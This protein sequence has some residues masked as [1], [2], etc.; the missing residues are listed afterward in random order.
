VTARTARVVVRRAH[1]GD[2]D[3][4]AAM[5]AALI[6]ASR[7]NPAYRR[8]RR[9]YVQVARPLF[10]AQLADA[11]C[12]TLLATADAQPVGLLR[13]TLSPPNPLHEPARHAYVVSVYVVPEQR[14]RGV[15]RSLVR[16]AERWC[17]AHDIDEMRLHVG[18]EN[19]AGNAAW[20]ALGF[21]PAEVLRVRRI[22][23]RRQRPA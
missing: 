2:L 8:L 13:C 9:D 7:R 18:V 11:R 14:R 17:R 20:D 16:A 19:R 10:A 22:P 3:A 5:R 1:A 23:R 12:L 4:V 15:L 21:E 6:E